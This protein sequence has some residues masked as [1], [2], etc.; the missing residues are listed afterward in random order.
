MSAL[1]TRETGPGLFTKRGFLDSR[2]EP[3]KRPAEA[4]MLPGLDAPLPATRAAVVMNAAGCNW[5]ES[6]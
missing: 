1:S 6:F 4:G 5:R 3:V 2:Q